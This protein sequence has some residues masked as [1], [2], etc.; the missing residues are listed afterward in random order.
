[1]TQQKNILSLTT[2]QHADNFLQEIKRQKANS[3][4]NT[5][6]V[7]AK[8]RFVIRLL[9]CL[10]KDVI[11]VCEG[12]R[13]DEN[14]GFQLANIGSLV[15][16]IMKWLFHHEQTVTKE[17]NTQSVDHKQGCISYEIKTSLGSNSLATPSETET[18]ILVNTVGIWS[19][20]K[21]DVHKY[22]NKQGRLPFN[23]ACGRPMA[24]MMEMLGYDSE[25]E[26]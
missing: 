9:N 17:F 12:C 5:A 13:G 3:N 25:I 10:P 26:E 2:T 16:C 19:I 11:L 18:T 22:T 7:I 24:K 20:S 4:S 21:K 23:K 6:K 15:E 8:C 14:R 1:M